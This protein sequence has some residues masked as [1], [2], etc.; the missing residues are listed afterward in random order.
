MAYLPTNGLPFIEEEEATGEVAELYEEMKREMQIPF[1]PNYFKALA[2]SPEALNSSWKM[3]YASSQHRTLPE[4]LIAMIS[5]T[6]STHSNC[7]YCSSGNELTC[8][9]L[10]VDQDTLD[11]LVK[12]LENLNPARVQAIIDFSLKV[13]EHPQE[14]V[15]ADY[16][17]VRDQG[18]LD[19]EI[20]EIIVTAAAA[21]YADIVADALQI[22]VDDI[23]QMALEQM[24]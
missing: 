14:L 18:V 7:L 23:T 13:A 2:G 22:E 12:D 19:N 11:K 17:K 8:R 20:V 24:R 1:V 5:Y 21:V 3:V 4:A 6:I 9:S 16:D 10:G 15:R